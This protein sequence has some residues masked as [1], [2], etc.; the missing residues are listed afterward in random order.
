[1]PPRSHWV[2]FS[3]SNMTQKTPEKPKIHTHLIENV[4]SAVT[5]IFFEDRYADKVIEK[6]FKN[7]RKW[8]ARDRRFFAENVYETVRW[9]RKLWYLIG[10]DPKTSTTDEFEL[11]LKAWAMQFLLQSGDLP[12]IFSAL[13]YSKPEALRARALKA[14]RSVQES[15][16]EWMDE[17]GSEQLQERW[18]AILKS[19]NGKASVDLRV[20][21]L[22]MSL[23]AA[24]QRLAEEEVET[25]TIPDVPTGLALKIRKNIFITD[26]FKNGGVEVQDRASQ[27]VAALLDPQPGDRVID[28]CAGAGGKSLHIA[29][30][31][32][33]KG[34]LISMDIFE[35]KLTE[36]KLRARRNG[37]SCLE[38]RWIENSKVIKRL[39]ESADKVLLDV[40]CSGFG[41]LRRN[42]DSKWKSSLE[43]LHK[44]E[45]LQAEILSNYSK[46][47]K[48]GGVLVYATCSV[49]P[50]ENEKQIE[51]FLQG[52]AGW[53]LEKQVRIDPDQGQGDGFFMARLLRS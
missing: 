53:T 35:R 10:E 9:W 34:K 51:K 32:Q 19:L 39:E 31:M 50:S 28:A 7:N 41:V 29:A 42:P 36:L 2:G 3:R 8:G 5:E 48:K 33:N 47:V 45:A 23:E 49:L 25:E 26:V 6:Y 18:P 21:T 44:L 27:R 22:K 4:A 13:N 46:M 37:V 24:K 30:L 52:S 12:E 40:P 1:M 38:T 17:V 15:V 14:P 16:P 20:N 11:S 43:E